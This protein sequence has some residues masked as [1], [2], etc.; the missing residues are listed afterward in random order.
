VWIVHQRWPPLN[1]AMQKSTQEEIRARFDR[2]VERF[3]NLETGQTATMDATIALELIQQ[4]ASRVVPHARA[5]LDLGCGAGNYTLKFL[6]VLPDLDVTLIDLSRPMLD[7]AVERLAGKTKSKVLALHG[8]IRELDIGEQR[9]DLI[10]AGMVLHHLR[11]TEEWNSVFRKLYKSLRTGGVFLVSDFVD[12]EIAPVHE[13]MWERYGEYLTALKDA[14]Y[15]DHVFG[16]VLK[17]DSPRSVTFQMEL[18]KECGFARVDV[19]HKNS[20]FAVFAA[21]KG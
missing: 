16:Y 19:L 8:D 21:V 14:A 1:N 17:E 7:R 15:R 2:E 9:F 6:Q 3:A 20:C 12:H 4:A 18:L 13:L 10:V 11:E 5:L